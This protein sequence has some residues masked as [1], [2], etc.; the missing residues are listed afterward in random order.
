MT[1]F[2]ECPLTLYIWKSPVGPLPVQSTNLVSH[3][4]SLNK[5][6]ILRPVAWVNAEKYSNLS[7]LYSVPSVR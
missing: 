6:L 4:L 2:G 7:S 5:A 3:L 1:I